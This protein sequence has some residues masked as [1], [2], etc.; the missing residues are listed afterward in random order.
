MEISPASP[1]CHIED[2]KQDHPD[3]AQEQDGTGG[4]GQQQN[5]KPVQGDCSGGWFSFDQAFRVGFIQH[6]NSPLLSY[7]RSTGP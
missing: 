3:Q 2:E 1:E 6:G 7:D 5:Q 4:H